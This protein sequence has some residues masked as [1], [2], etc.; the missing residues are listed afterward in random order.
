MP[1]IPCKHKLVALELCQI[2]EP[3]EN[4]HGEAPSIRFCIDSSML[5]TLH[6]EIV[7]L[8]TESLLAT[9]ANASAASSLD[10]QTDNRARDV[11]I[12]NKAVASD[13]NLL[14]LVLVESCDA[15]H[16]VPVR[17]DD[18]VSNFLHRFN[19]AFRGG[20]VDAAE[21]I[22]EVSERSERRAFLASELVAYIDT[23]IRADAARQ[24]EAVRALYQQQARTKYELAAVFQDI[25]QTPQLIGPV[26]A[27]DFPLGIVPG[28]CSAVF[29][30]CSF[31]NGGSGV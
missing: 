3:A 11:P 2:R 24:N 20:A 18:G 22:N 5:H 26:P 10:N 29:V 30:S 6:R 15:K 25:V 16:E 1:A 27:A 31:I 17:R 19:D 13:S 12:T 8:R 4:A 28:L 7:R 14:N 23:S 21:W 9:G